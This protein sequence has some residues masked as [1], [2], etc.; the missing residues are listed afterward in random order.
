M[1]LKYRFTDDRGEVFVVV[2]D[3][4]RI[5]IYRAATLMDMLSMNEDDILKVPTKVKEEL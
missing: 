4:E 3:H 2:R 5:A 1:E